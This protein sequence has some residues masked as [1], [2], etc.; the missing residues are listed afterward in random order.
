[1]SQKNKNYQQLNLPYT[2]YIESYG[3][4][5]KSIKTQLDEIVKQFLREHILISC[6]S[7]DSDAKGNFLETEYSLLYYEE[8][9]K[10]KSIKNP[11]K[12]SSLL[13]YLPKRNRAKHYSHPP[14]LLKDNDYIPYY[15]YCFTISNNV[16]FSQKTQ[17]RKTPSHFRPLFILHEN[18][19]NDEK[20]F[21]KNHYEMVISLSASDLL[22][23]CSGD[24]TKEIKEG[25]EYKSFITVL[26]NTLFGEFIILKKLQTSS[27]DSKQIPKLPKEGSMIQTK[28]ASSDEE[29]KKNTTNFILTNIKDSGDCVILT[30][31]RSLYFKEH[32]HQM[33]TFASQEAFLPISENKDKIKKIEEDEEMGF[34]GEHN[35]KTTLSILPFIN[36]LTRIVTTDVFDLSTSKVSKA[37]VF[38]NPKAGKTKEIKNLKQKK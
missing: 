16:L 28:Y 36:K 1:M 6:D 3:F 20:V 5:P 14:V 18:D 8:Q 19:I 21:V 30:R 38:L 13:T 33:I 24:N 2:D 4:S 23:Y 15:N 10:Q 32:V 17:E 26:T 29:D 9:C 25:I 35:N 7:Y 22:K 34:Y 12:N 37:V 27:V 31:D 11:F